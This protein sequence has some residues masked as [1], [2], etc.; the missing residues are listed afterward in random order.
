[1][2]PFKAVRR[3]SWLFIWAA[4]LHTV[5][6]TPGLV[7]AAS[8]DWTSL[9][10]EGGS[11]NAISINPRDPNML[12]AATAYASF[13]SENG[14]RSWVKSTRPMPTVAFDLQN[15][16]IVYARPPLNHAGYLF[17]STDQGRNW[18]DIGPPGTS[19]TD[20]ATSFQDTKT[21]FL[22]AIGGVF[23]STNAGE[24]WRAVN[25]GLPRGVAVQTLAVHPQNQNTVYIGTQ[26]GVFKTTNGGESWNIIKQGE[27]RF[28]LAVDPENGDTIYVAPFNGPVSSS[29]DGGK[30]WTTSNQP[31]GSSVF[32]LVIDPYAPRTIYACC[33]PGGFGLENR[34]WKSTD[35]GE[36]WADTGLTGIQSFAIDPRNSATLYAGTRRGVLKSVDGGESWTPFNMGL[37]S[38]PVRILAVDPQNQ[39]TLYGDVDGPVKS[40]DGGMTWTA[41]SGL[42]G[43]HYATYAMAINPQTADTIYASSYEGLFKS[44]DGRNVDEYGLARQR[45]GNC[46]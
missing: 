30:T 36:S 3:V 44:T 27:S 15:P 24:S 43:S 5:A 22:A 37:L 21:M 40:I 23:K 17:K 8:N 39:D 34:L 4:A 33:G 26:S 9:G 46:C 35:A 29:T 28:A 31:Q 6:M 41:I 16:N 32:M 14:G 1:M 10:P 11:I 13:T 19:V 25:S 12:Y 45:E 42:K 7:L 2:K 38:M 18:K 20:F